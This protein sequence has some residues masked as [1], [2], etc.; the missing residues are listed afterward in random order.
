MSERQFP[1]SFWDSHFIQRHFHNNTHFPPHHTHS[2]FPHT[3]LPAHSSDFYGV[4]TFPHGMTS[5]S[6]Q[7]MT[8]YHPAAHAQ[9]T[10]PVLH[11]LTSSFAAA[12][13]LSVHTGPAFTPFARAAAKLGGSSNCLTSQFPYDFKHGASLQSGS[14]FWNS[15]STQPRYNSTHAYDV[16]PD[17]F[18]TS[19]HSQDSYSSLYSGALTAS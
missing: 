6:D 16:M 7:W 8:R 3:N 18:V 14:D 13:R 1:A 10:Y 5:L 12:N 19:Q 11:D 17:P 9:H 4:P 2:H 15:T